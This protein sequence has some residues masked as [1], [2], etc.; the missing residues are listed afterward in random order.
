[1]APSSGSGRPRKYCSDACRRAFYKGNAAGPSPEAERHDAYVRQIVEE[2]ALRVDRIR[3]LA[4]ADRTDLTGSASL[5]TLSLALLQSSAE[6]AKDL[7]DLDAAV[8][9]QA[10]DRGVKVGDIAKSR[11]ISADKVSRDWPADSIDRRMHQR[12]QRPRPPRPRTGYGGGSP[13]N[14]MFLPGQHLAG[15]GPDPDADREGHDPPDGRLRGRP[16]RRHRAATRATRPP[17]RGQSAIGTARPVTR[18]RGP[19][20][21]RSA[22]RSP[23]LTLLPRATAA[24]ALREGRP[25]TLD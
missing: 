6:M 2:L 12:Q 14:D 13:L 19:P 15:P 17:R 16:R 1:M 25:A 7:Q 18:T 4:H 3:N 21:S 11:N 22:V 9:Q 20:G 10:R 23:G 5:R 24:D 8:V